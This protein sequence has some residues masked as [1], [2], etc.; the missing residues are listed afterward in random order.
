MESKGMAGSI[1]DHDRLIRSRYG[2]FK[3][4]TPRVR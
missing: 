1:R 2:G 4:H 3:V